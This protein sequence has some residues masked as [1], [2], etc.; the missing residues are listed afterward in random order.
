MQLARAEGALGVVLAP[1]VLLRRTL[2]RVV[3][4]ARAW[5][6]VAK[7]APAS[8][9]TVLPAASAFGGT[10]AT[11]ATAA[12]VTVSIATFGVPGQH[13]APA[14]TGAAAAAVRTTTASAPGG[15]LIRPSTEMS[16]AAGA[17]RSWRSG[18]NALSGA[19][20]TSHG[21]RGSGDR[22]ASHVAFGLAGQH[23]GGRG[24][25]NPGTKGSVRSGTSGRSGQRSRRHHVGAGRGSEPTK[26]VTAIVA[27][28]VLATGRVGTTLLRAVHAIVG[29]SPVSKVVKIVAGVLP[30]VLTVLPKVSLPQLTL[31]SLP[32]A[33]A[34]PLPLPLPKLALPSVPALTAPV[35]TPPIPLPAG[36]LPA[37][38]AVPVPAVPVPAAAIPTATTESARAV[39]G[40]GLPSVPLPAAVLPSVP[41]L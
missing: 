38:P 3:S 13:R 17:I 39:P 16:A 8:A 37:V 23:A 5:A 27:T 21:L 15:V 4:S 34:P 30:K 19:A 14:R 35:P 36:P 12:L 26:V 32:V 7:G 33:T 11:L 1:L 25:I 2:D 22:P 20:R 28:G 6:A 10:V 41:T 29:S 40:T 24:A 9:G 31:P 18:R